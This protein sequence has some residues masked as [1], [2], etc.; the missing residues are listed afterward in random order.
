MHN[1]QTIANLERHKR[2]KEVS[3]VSIVKFVWLLRFIEIVYVSFSSRESWTVWH[4]KRSHLSNSDLKLD[5]NIRAKNSAFELDKANAYWDLDLQQT[6]TT[7]TK[8]EWHV[9]RAYLSILTLIWSLIY[10]VDFEKYQSSF[11]KLQWENKTL[12]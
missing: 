4:V 7:H 10:P 2:S 1:Q 5:L 8:I 3:V 11:L 12:L 9:N 6:S